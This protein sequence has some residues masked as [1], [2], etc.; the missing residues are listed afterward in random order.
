MRAFPAAAITAALLV[1]SA[2][3]LA[4]S[5]SPAPGQALDLTIGTLGLGAGLEFPASERWGFRVGVSGWNFNTHYNESGVEYKARLKLLN[6]PMLADW[7]P[8][9]GRFRITAGIVPN[10]DKF[11]LDAQASG[12]GTFTFNDR[13]YNARDVGSATGTIRYNRVAPY[14]GAG[15]ARP[16][17]RSERWGFGMDFG[18]M[19]L[20]RPKTNLTVTC[21]S[22]MSASNCAQLQRDV[23]AEADELSRDSDDYRWYPVIQ[24]HFGWKF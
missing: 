18:V 19:Y 23:Q 22:A 12:T 20:G 11:R 1:V 9:G 17:G 15:F 7:R 5:R 10:D 6:V 16:L 4:Q 3:A 8:T 24:A 21:S 13:T 14:I 2:P